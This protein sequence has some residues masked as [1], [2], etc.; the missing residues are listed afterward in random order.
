M[1]ETPSDGPPSKNCS[2]IN[3]VSY[4]S[5]VDRKNE[6]VEFI[7]QEDKSTSR[8]KKTDYVKYTPMTSLVLGASQNSFK[9]EV[10]LTAEQD[11]ESDPIEDDAEV[12]YISL[13]SA[14]S[15]PQTQVKS[16][17][18][19]IPA[20]EGDIFAPWRPKKSQTINFG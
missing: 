7:C 13:P 1:I 20:I 5:E 12:S 3:S 15:A 17:I 19:T 8:T 4:S 2:T 10:D 9:E 6:E 18:P 14:Y 16:S 11:S